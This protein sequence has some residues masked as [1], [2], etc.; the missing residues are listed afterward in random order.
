MVRRGTYSIVARDPESGALGVAVQSHWFSVG[1]VVAWARAGVGAVA[2]QSIP[3]AAQGTRLLDLLD[4]GARPD[5]AIDALLA[6]DEAGAYRQTAAVDAGGRVAVHTG[7]ACIPDAGHA[8]GDGWACQANMMASAEVWPAMAERYVAAEGRPFPERLL[9]ALQAAEAS[10]GDVR[11]S[12]S[13]VLLVVPGERGEAW[14][15]SVD[16]RVDDHPD[17]VG[18]L[19]RLLVLH[20][21]YALAEEADGLVAEGRLAEAG[22]RYEAAAELAPHSDELLFWAGLAR[23]AEGDRDAGLSQVRRAVDA[24]PGWLELLPRL[25]PEVAPSAAAVLEAL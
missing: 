12:Q 17:P 10:G 19:A 25:T 3:D 21:A 9:A 6:T 11:G 15:R 2:V 7:G 14:R 1:S 23:F 20:R 8:T 13:A 18:E 4:E 24:N 16:L 5:Q 22:Q